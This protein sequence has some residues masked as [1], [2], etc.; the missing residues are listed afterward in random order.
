[1]YSHFIEHQNIDEFSEKKLKIK[2]CGIKES[3]FFIQYFFLCFGK[4]NEIFLLNF[5]RI[6]GG[7]FFS[8]FSLIMCFLFHHPNYFREM[9]YYVYYHQINVS[10]HCIKFNLFP[11]S[12]GIFILYRGSNILQMAI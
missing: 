4:E 8:F 2:S 9:Y 12:F 3:F 7:F 11:I 1:M 6:N 5:L 10:I